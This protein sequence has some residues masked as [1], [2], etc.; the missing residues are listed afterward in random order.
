M[1]LLIIGIS[2]GHK[3]LFAGKAAFFNQG[4]EILLQQLILVWLKITAFIL[5]K[6]IILFILRKQVMIERF[7]E[8]VIGT[9]L[10]YSIHFVFHSRIFPIG[11]QLHRYILGKP[12][13]VDHKANYSV[14]LVDLRA[15]QI[16]LPGLGY[17][18]KKYI[19]FIIQIT[20]FER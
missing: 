10:S 11:D 4:I 16:N 6:Q 20:A 7:D 19:G 8:V 17:L 12:G 9:E 1:L 14:F 2:K 13:V 5:D 3:I 15:N 18:L